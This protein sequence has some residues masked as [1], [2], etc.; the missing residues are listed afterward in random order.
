MLSK[1]TRNQLIITT[2]S[3]WVRD[4]AHIAIFSKDGFREL[5]ERHFEKV[6]IIDADRTWVAVCS[7]PKRS[8]PR[9]LYLSFVRFDLVSGYTTQ[10]QYQLRAMV[11][12]YDVVYA[13]VRGADSAKHWEPIRG[14]ELKEIDL[15]PASFWTDEK[16]QWLNGFD[17]IVY[18]HP[19][20]WEVFKPH[21]KPDRAFFHVSGTNIS[22][23]IN[24]RVS[25]SRGVI[26]QGSEVNLDYQDRGLPQNKALPIPCTV[27]VNR[28]DMNGKPVFVALTSITKDKGIPE[29][30]D[31]LEPLKDKMR[32]IIAGSMLPNHVSQEPDYYAWLKEK[33]DTGWGE[34]IGS[35]SPAAIPLLLSSCTAVIHWNRMKGRYDE[36]LQS[37]K[38]LEAMAAGKPVIAFGSKGTISLVGKKY[39]YVATDETGLKAAVEEILA[40]PGKA[41]KHGRALQR[42]VRKYFDS[43]PVGRLW[44]DLIKKNTLSG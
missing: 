4:P 41:K 19:G 16:K 29:M 13:M 2:P 18:R 31:A 28:F 38:I 10:I 40:S 37:T 42:R 32:L 43:E 6:E 7:G 30:L 26:M 8:K 24:N 17:I 22:R 36:T 1:T 35:V 14:V 12:A 25:E 34:W 9:L 15:P 11:Q 3:T 23:L 44:A 27:P 33:L 5:L 20:L 21:V 39:P